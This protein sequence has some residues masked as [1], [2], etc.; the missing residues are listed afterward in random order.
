MT[1]ASWREIFFIYSLYSTPIPPTFH[2]RSV[3]LYIIIF[4]ITFALVNNTHN[5]NHHY[6][7]S[8]KTYQKLSGAS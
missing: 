1:W 7:Q 5:N 6:V 4:I 3:P 8:N 2:Y